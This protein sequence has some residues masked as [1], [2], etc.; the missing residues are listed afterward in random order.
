MSHA[1][2]KIAVH[3]DTFDAVYENGIMPFEK[4]VKE[5]L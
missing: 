2:H 4:F 1:M 5:E 3:H